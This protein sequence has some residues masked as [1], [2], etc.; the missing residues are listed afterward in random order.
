MKRLSLFLLLLLVIAGISFAWEAE[1]LTKFPPCMNDK[2]VILNFGIGFNGYFFDYIGNKYYTYVPPIRLSFDFNKGLG[3]KALPFFFGGLVVYSGHFFKNDILKWSYSDLRLG[4][5]AGYHFNWGVDN[6]DTYAVTTTG[7]T[8]RF[9]DQKYKEYYERN[10]SDLFLFDIGFGARW[11][12]NEFFGFWAELGYGSS[13]LNV[14]LSF[15]F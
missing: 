1:D 4:F 9:S 7:W 13:W 15:K 14:G 10:F 2:N 5:R 11:F 6:L 3:D 12:V 8:I